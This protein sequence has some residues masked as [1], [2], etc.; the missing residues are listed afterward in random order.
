MGG[1]GSP[2]TSDGQAPCSSPHKAGDE[3]MPPFTSS[4]FTLL[5]YLFE[6]LL[7]RNIMELLQIYVD[8]VFPMPRFANDGHSPPLRYGSIVV[9]HSALSICL[10]GVPGM[11]GLS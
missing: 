2:K 1:W 11:S 5:L 8:G 7:D 3:F 10:K 9:A 4:L 6:R